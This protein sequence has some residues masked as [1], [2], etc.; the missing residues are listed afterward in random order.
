MHAIA[1]VF[2]PQSFTAF[3]EKEIERLSSAFYALVEQNKP[4]IKWLIEE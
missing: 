2:V 4:L 1:Y 3:D